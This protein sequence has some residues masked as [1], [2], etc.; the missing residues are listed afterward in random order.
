MKVMAEQEIKDKRSILAEKVKNKELEGKKHFSIIL[1]LYAFCF[2]TY[3]FTMSAGFYYL[4]IGAA[5]SGMVLSVSIVDNPSYSKV[6]SAFGILISIFTSFT[7]GSYFRGDHAFS[8]DTAFD[9]A[10]FFYTL[11]IL[12]AG[13]LIGKKLK[14]NGKKLESLKSTLGTFDYISPESNP[15][16]CLEYAAWI[17]KQ[18]SDVLDFH[19][20]L[21]GRR[22]T[23]VE[24]NQLKGIIQKKNRP[25]TDIE[26][27]EK[28]CEKLFANAENCSENDK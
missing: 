15:Q 7:A 8:V 12:A 13:L 4:A 28:A 19:N 18:D 9:Y 26:I 6:I 27:A 24:I 14:K 22:P 2:I 25:K 16:D 1:L 17:E 10:L 20:Q 21:N 5:I 23:L 11:C 3:I